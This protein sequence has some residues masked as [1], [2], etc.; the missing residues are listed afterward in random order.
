MTF[1]PLLNA[2]LE[3][4]IHVAF[5]LMSVMFGPVALFRARRDKWHKRLGYICVSTMG[6]TA[7]SGF[8]IS[9]TA[10]L[11]PFNPIHLL[12]AMALWGLFDG[13]RRILRGD[14]AGHRAAMRGVYFWGLGLAGLFA[15]LPGRRMNV[16]VFGEPSWLGFL[17][18]G[19]VIGALLLWY[20]APSRFVA[21]RV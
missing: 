4:Q 7:F 10:M 16:A 17:L 13:M 20:R 21:R 1:E 5:A 2:P 14:V 12:S 15:F 6:I 8:F 9:T 3:V 18:V 19:S 11:G